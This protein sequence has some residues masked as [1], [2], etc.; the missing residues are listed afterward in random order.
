MAL[1]RAGAAAGTPG[2]LATAAR[3]LGAG[4]D[5]DFDNG[6]RVAHAQHLVVVEIALFHTPTRNGD[7]AFQ[8][9]RQP[10]I[11]CPLHLRLHAKGIHGGA[12]IHGTN[13]AI[14]AQSA[15]LRVAGNFRDLR[16][17]TAPAKS[18]GD[19]ASSARPQRLVPTSLL[20]G[21]LEDRA[22]A[23]HIERLSI[24]HGDLSR[25]TK[26][27]EQEFNRIPAGGMRGLIKETRDHE[28]IARGIH[29]T[30]IAEGHAGFG[31]SEFE[32]KVGNEERGKVERI[33]LG[34]GL[35]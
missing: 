1:P 21:Q 13:D 17:V 14:D 18:G 22:A 26:R 20:R 24:S 4:H 8:G 2:R 29:G 32:T 3:R 31:D 11:D 10:K 9:L 25:R 16:D 15:V 23:A 35:R 6:G 33:D 7:C 19:A 30:L 5:V 12:T 34:R 28:L 27:G